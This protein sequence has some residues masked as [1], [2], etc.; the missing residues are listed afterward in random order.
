MTGFA[1]WNSRAWRCRGPLNLAK[2]RHCT[3]WPDSPR[4]GGQWA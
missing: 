3:H 4:S 1:Q 2:Y